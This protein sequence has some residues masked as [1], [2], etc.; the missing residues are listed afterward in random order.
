ML[1]MLVFWG[2]RRWMLDGSVEL[3]RTRC[4]LALSVGKLGF[5]KGLQKRVRGFVLGLWRRELGG[6]M[7]EY[8]YEWTRDVRD[9]R[10]KRVLI[11]FR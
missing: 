1:F 11:S 8:G 7:E 10:K 5:E 4:S 2:V 6:K 3:G 9:T